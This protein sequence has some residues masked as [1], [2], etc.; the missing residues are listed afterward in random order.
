M[1]NLTKIYLASLPKE[2]LK[3]TGEIRSMAFI[4]TDRHCWRLVSSEGKA[5]ILK[6]IY[7]PPCRV[8]DFKLICQC[9]IAAFQNVIK[10]CNTNNKDEYWVLNEWVSGST[11]NPIS[12]SL[13]NEEQKSQVKQ[14]ANRLRSIHL[15]N[16]T[17]STVI[18]Q[19][20][21]LRSLLNCNFIKKNTQEMLLSYMVDKL[22]MIQARHCT[23]VHGDLHIKN[24]IL[25]EDNDIVFIDMDDI[26]YGDPYIDLVYASNLIC[27]ADEYYTYYLLLNYYFEYEIPTEFWPIV[28]FYS[29]LKA[30][31]IMTSEAAK[32]IDRKP[33]LSIEGLIR[34]H[35]GFTEE[36]PLW[37]TQICKMLGGK[38]GN[39]QDEN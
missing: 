8:R 16:Q 36:Q 9:K 3:C 14:I 10:I 22:P 20:D 37:Y 26:R 32:S 29:V 21:T 4:G 1:D 13:Q 11:F 18:L 23:I 7:L 28:N 27:S 33:I 15:E 38:L 6:R 19:E 30:I 39:V 34:Q 35:R 25:T 31:N 17:N 2:I 24:I 5:Y 12:L